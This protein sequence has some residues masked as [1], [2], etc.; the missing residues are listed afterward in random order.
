MLRPLLLASSVIAAAR[1]HANMVIPTSRNAFDGTLPEFIGG[2]AVGTACTCANGQECD[3]G[4]REMGGQGQPCLWWSQACSIGCDYCL[5]DPRHPDNNG[6]IPTTAITGNAPHADKAG[7]RKAYCD[8]PAEPVLPKPYWTMNIHATDG[9]VDDSYRYNPWRAPGTAPVVDPCG[10][11]GGKFLQ[12]PMGGDSEFTTVLVHGKN[13]SMGDMGS[14]LPPTIG[15]LPQWVAGADVQ[16]A[17]GMRFNHGGGYQYRL[18]PADSP[19]TEEC[20]QQHPLDFVRGSQ[21]I[22]WNNGSSRPIPAMYVDDTVCP[23]VPAGST[24]ARSPVPRINTDNDGLAFEGNCTTGGERR[25]W[26]SAAKKDCEQFPNPCPDIDE[27]WFKCDDGYEQGGCDA[28]GN[29]DHWGY[30]SGDWTLGMV[31][32]RVVVPKELPPGKYVVGWRL[33]CEETAQIWQNC[34]DVEVVAPPVE[35]AAA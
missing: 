34:A 7:F 30:C 10:Q 12:A 22:M 24:W 4:V 31:A 6:T 26:W 20:F 35:M 32:D 15:P 19:L 3:M 18:C 9:A 16:V 25:E 2:K 29:N 11:A 13:W 8:K 23:V 1:G 27:D 14:T 28:A 17:W 5:T 21:A 33:D